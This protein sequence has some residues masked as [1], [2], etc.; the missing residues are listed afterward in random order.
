MAFSP[1]PLAALVIHI[2]MMSFKLQGTTGIKVLLCLFLN[3]FLL[4]LIVG[5]VLLIASSSNLDS[6]P[7]K[8][9]PSSPIGKTECENDKNRFNCAKMNKINIFHSINTQQT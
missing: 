2:S 3:L 1:L 9:A 6:E 4:K 5:L 8:K 7:K